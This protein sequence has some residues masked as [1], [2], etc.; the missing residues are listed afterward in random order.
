M[1][2]P[3]NGVISALQLLQDDRLDDEQKR[4]LDAAM[5]SGE[6]LL[7]HINDV[8]AIERSEAGTYEQVR[9][10]CDMTVLMAGIINTMDPLAEAGARGCT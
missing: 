1:R 8:L 4:Y 9:Q 6:I 10:T 5:T 2:T 3:L 7:G